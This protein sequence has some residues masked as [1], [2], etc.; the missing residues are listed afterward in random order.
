MKKRVRIYQNGGAQQAQ[1]GPSPEQVMQYVSQLM[2]SPQYDGNPDTIMNELVQQGV[3]PQMAQAVIQEVLTIQQPQQMTD[4]D[5]DAAA[6]ERLQSLYATNESATDTDI[7][8]ENMMRKGG[9]KCSKK[10]YV[11]NYMKLAKKQAGGEADSTDVQNGRNQKVNGFINTVKQTANEAKLKEQAEA[12]YEQQYSNPFGE[13]QEQGYFRGGG[14]VRRAVRQADRMIPP[15]LAGQALSQFTGPNTQLAN[16]DVRRSGMFGR[17]K[18][19]T[20]NFEPIA[21]PVTNAAE[22]AE[23]IKKVSK[24]AAEQAEMEAQNAKNTAKEAQEY[25]QASRTSTANSGKSKSKSAPK[26]GSETAA[27]TDI[28]T[29]AETDIETDIEKDAEMDLKTYLETANFETVDVDAIGEKPFIDPYFGLT[30]IQKYEKEHGIGIY[31]PQA[32][33]AD[34]E[35]ITTLVLGAGN[36]AI[37]AGNKA[38]TEIAKSLLKRV[39]FRQAKEIMSS[40]R[41]LNNG[42]A[43][44]LSSGSSSPA[45]RGSNLPSVPNTGM[46]AGSSGFNPMTYY[47]RFIPSA[48]RTPYGQMLGMDAFPQQPEPTQEE[49]NLQEAQRV[50][51]I[52]QTGGAVYDQYMQM[53]K[54]LQMQKMNRSQ[55]GYDPLRIGMRSPVYRSYE[56][57]GITDANGNPVSNM[58]YRNKGVSSIDVAKSSIFGRPKRFD[59]TYG[60]QGVAPTFDSDRYNDDA[61]LPR[62]E[63]TFTPQQKVGNFLYKVKDKLQKAQDGLSFQLPEITDDGNEPFGLPTEQLTGEQRRQQDIKKYRQ[64]QQIMDPKYKDP[65]ITENDIFGR[66]DTSVTESYDSKLKI[67]PAGVADAAFAGANIFNVFAEGVDDNRRERQMMDRITNP[68]FIYG[69][70]EQSDKGDYDMNS[71][72]YRPDQMGNMRNAQT[73]GE[74]NEEVYMTDE[75]I[76]EFLAN[77]GQLEYL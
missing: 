31:G 58:D 28:E 33:H 1:Q 59:V 51:G 50:L 54:Q 71:G 44:Q 75:E 32:A 6:R 3:D 64:N 48:S 5:P 36:W 56:S 73:G 2:A 18:E 45:I 46:T 16:I 65:N 19:Y 37:N 23:V 20:I 22:A 35:L 17:P 38:T 8:A 49:L 4:P 43:G 57:T 67:N 24:T 25:K 21:Q 40:G 12:L 53:L 52:K 7:P 13:E 62:N 76:E 69:V 34:D 27:E 63:N 61:N 66:A 11:N 39:G 41:Q 77:G 74:L 72:L 26:K 47:T 60:D 29:A 9:A 70:N 10:K 42:Q 68:E 30:D 15:V 14:H 55:R